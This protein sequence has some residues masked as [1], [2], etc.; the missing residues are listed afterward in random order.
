MEFDSLSTLS[1]RLRRHQFQKNVFHGFSIFFINCGDNKLDFVYLIGV[2]IIG[3]LSSPCRRR[4][5][6]RSSFHRSPVAGVSAQQLS[7]LVIF[8]HHRNWC[9]SEWVCGFRGSR[10]FRQVGQPIKMLIQTSSRV[11]WAQES[12]NPQTIIAFAVNLWI[13][14]LNTVEKQYTN[15]PICLR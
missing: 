1:S 12:L 5:G 11:E 8:T 7:W 10:V 14:F 3:K 15:K 13:K 9:L 2:L 6:T 4:P